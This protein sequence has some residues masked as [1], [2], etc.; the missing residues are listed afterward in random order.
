[1]KIET[2]FK[3][4][5]DPSEKLQHATKYAVELSSVEC[6]WH[7]RRARVVVSMDDKGELKWSINNACCD[8]LKQELAKVIQEVSPK[9]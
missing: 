9:G 2:T 4:G 7:N 5:D 1:M 6:S 3:L 8:D